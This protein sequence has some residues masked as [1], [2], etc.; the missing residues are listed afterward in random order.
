ME[1]LAYELRHSGSPEISQFERDIAER[2]NE[3]ARARI[4]KRERNKPDL[5]AANRLA[6]RVFWHTTRGRNN[7][8]G[9]GLIAPSEVATYLHTWLPE[10]RLDEE[11][12]EDLLLAVERLDERY[13]NHH[14][15]K[16]DTRPPL[17][18]PDGRPVV[19]SD[20]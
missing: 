13:Y 17:V 2:G 16:K 9:M 19:P 8:M 3:E 6:W 15:K 1:C 4:E 14:N 12:R 11:E 7:G 20:G 10:L 18:G 5:W